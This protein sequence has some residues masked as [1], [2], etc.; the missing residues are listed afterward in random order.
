MTAYFKLRLFL[1]S[2]G[3]DPFEFYDRAGTVAEARLDV[4]GYRTFEQFS[5]SVRPHLSAVPAEPSKNSL[6]G[7]MVTEGGR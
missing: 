2:H 7:L 1:G 4:E 3:R 6:F 5:E